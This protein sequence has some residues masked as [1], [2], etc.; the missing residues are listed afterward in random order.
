MEIKIVTDKIT[1]DEIRQMATESYGEMVKAVADIEQGIMA[2]GGEWHADAEALLLDQGSKQ[3][4]LWGFN[5]YPDRP[6][7]QQVEFVSLINIR[8]RQ[9]NRRMDIEDPAIREKISQIVR[10]LIIF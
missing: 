9:K 5:I 3:M 8:P 10:K 6:V 1:I 7:H 2:V 4:D